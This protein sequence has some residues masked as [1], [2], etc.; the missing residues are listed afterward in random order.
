MKMV[1]FINVQKVSYEKAKICNIC[2][3]ISKINTIMINIIVKLQTIVITLSL[4]YTE[5]LQIEYVI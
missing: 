3:K 2:K 4:H 1:P 5:V